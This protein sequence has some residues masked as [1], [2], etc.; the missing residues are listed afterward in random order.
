MTDSLAF[1]R[2]SVAAAPVSASRP[3]SAFGSPGDAA[4]DSYIRICFAQDAARLAEGLERIA[5]AI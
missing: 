4:A 3:G 2:R 5:G 1:A